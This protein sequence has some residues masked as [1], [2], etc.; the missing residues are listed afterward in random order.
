MDKEPTF[1][2]QPVDRTPYGAFAWIVVLSLAI[3][4]VGSYGL[5]KFGGWA[6]YRN[7]ALSSQ[8]TGATDAYLEKGSSVLDQASN[9]ATKAANDAAAN[10]TQALLNQQNAAIKAGASAAADQIKIQADQQIQQFI[11]K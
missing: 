3:L 11:T 6:K 1:Y 5:W 8:H 9:A 10:A 4:F 7:F 2:E